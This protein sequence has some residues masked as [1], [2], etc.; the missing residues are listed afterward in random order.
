VNEFSNDGSRSLQQTIASP[1]PWAGPRSTYSGWFP[2]CHEQLNEQLSPSRDSGANPPISLNSIEPCLAVSVY[3]CKAKTWST[4][5]TG[6]DIFAVQRIIRC[7]KQKCGVKWWDGPYLDSKAYL[8]LTVRSC[9]NWMLLHATNQCSLV[10]PIEEALQWLESR[11]RAGFES[12]PFY[13]HSLGPRIITLITPELTSSFPNFLFDW[14]TSIAFT[15]W[16]LA[17]WLGIWGHDRQSSY[18]WLAC[19]T[20]VL[21]FALVIFMMVSM[22]ILVITSSADA[23]TAVLSERSIIWR[24]VDNL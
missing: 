8:K 9:I 1:I 22:A 15:N 5:F 6:F 13:P 7:E 17:V 19:A 12:V 21:L 20:A 3:F 2:A 18:H 14:Y 16:T 24:L 11:L 4:T 10:Q 23:R